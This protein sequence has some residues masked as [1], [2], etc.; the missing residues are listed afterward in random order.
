MD[1]KDY[2]YS[3]NISSLIRKES[4]NF[5]VLTDYNYLN[6]KSQLK[7]AN[8][9]SADYC[10]IIGDDESNSNCCQIKNME[11]GNQDRINFDDIQKYLRKNIIQ[12]K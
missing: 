6:L 4:K 12:E 8:K 5:I 2:L 7:K 3:Q 10:V 1:K 11:S 9:L